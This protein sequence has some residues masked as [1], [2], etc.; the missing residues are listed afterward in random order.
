MEPYVP[1]PP[2]PTPEQW[3]Q[4]GLWVT[5]GGIVF[6]AGGFA[7]LVQ[8]GMAVRTAMFVMAPFALL[9]LAFGWIFHSKKGRSLVWVRS[10]WAVA[11]L[12]VVLVESCS[13]K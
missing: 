12:A 6:A 1:P 11:L 10:I 9:A 7:W 13:G 5:L 4:M 2:A 8:D 3:E